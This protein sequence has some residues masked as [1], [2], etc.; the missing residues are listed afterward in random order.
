MNKSI[1]IQEQRH[2]IWKTATIVSAALCVIFLLIYWYLADPFWI[3]IIRL[4]AFISFAGTVL[5]YLKLRDG[6]LHITLNSSDELLLISYQKKGKTIQEEQFERGSI[7]EIISTSSQ[8]NLVNRFLHPKTAV[9]KI[10]FTDSDRTLYLFEFGGRPLLF[11]RPS[12]KKIEKFLHNLEID[13]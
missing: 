13:F 4:C 9:F 10:S 1:T 2:E 5:G 7:K 8:Q 11:D 6:P 12:Q 3:S